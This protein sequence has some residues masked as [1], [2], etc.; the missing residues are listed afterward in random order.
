MAGYVSKIDKST[1]VKSSIEAVLTEYMVDH[2]TRRGPP[3]TTVTAGINLAGVDLGQ[4][5]LSYAL[6]W[7]RTLLRLGCV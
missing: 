7:P 6:L 2:W 3:D 1:A 5:L 4:F